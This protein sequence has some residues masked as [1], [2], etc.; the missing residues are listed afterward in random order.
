MPG[1][2]GGIDIGTAVANGIY[3][4]VTFEHQEVQPIYVIHRDTVKAFF[5]ETKH[6]LS[7]EGKL[8]GILGIE[9]SLIVSL[10]TATFN[11]WLGLKGEVIEASFFVLSVIFGVF[12]ILET[13]SWL[14]NGGKVKIDA[15]TDELGK[16]GSII[17]P[18][19]CDA[20][21]AQ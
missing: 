4:N 14:A 13:V 18:M 20:E 5:H 3:A 21:Q 12:L 6:R 1:A 7:Q 16:R 17:R 2:R 8:L 11:P 9:L 19:S 10:V 15:L